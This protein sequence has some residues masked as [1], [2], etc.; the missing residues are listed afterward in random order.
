MYLSLINKGIG[1]AVRVM[2]YK[3][4]PK[5]NFYW[6]EG[7]TDNL[8]PERAKIIQNHIDSIFIAKKRLQHQKLNEKG[9]EYNSY[10]LKDSIKIN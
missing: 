10:Y 9:L 4:N 6:G 1:G 2:V 7:F 5:I 8:T 3:K